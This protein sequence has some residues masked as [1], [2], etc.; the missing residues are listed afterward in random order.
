MH[1]GNLEKAKEDLE[2]LMEID[3]NNTNGI[4]DLKKLDALLKDKNKEN[5]INQ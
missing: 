5:E 3:P 4:K 1:Y 2:E